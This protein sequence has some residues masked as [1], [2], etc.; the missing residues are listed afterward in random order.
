MQAN[1][2]K[3]VGW[4][5]THAPET[6]KNL[7]PPATDASIAAVEQVVGLSLPDA[8]K[9]F[10]RIHDG[11][12]EELNALFGD[13]NKLL[14]CDEIIT[15]YQLDQHI[16]NMLYD[17]SME[18]VDFWQDRTRNQIMFIKGGVKPLRLHP[19]WIPLTVMN[20]DVFRYLD[21]DP[22]PSG[23]MGQVIE[24]DPEGCSWQVLANSFE[25]LLSQYALA[26]TNGLYTVDQEVDEGY[27]VS[28]SSNNVC[29]WGMPEWLENA[30]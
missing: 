25:E 10:L 6:L 20:G 13:S 15:Q 1:F 8:Y 18:T 21:Y 7:N 19:K 2:E 3:I 11:E 4:I 30:E 27:I 29:D 26:L 5:E 9:Q 22:A 28:L 16:G 24:V 17:P 12:R 14:S 23:V